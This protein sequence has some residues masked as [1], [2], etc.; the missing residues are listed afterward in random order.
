METALKTNY[1][2]GQDKQVN[3]KIILSGLITGQIAGLI[4]AVAIILVFVIF[5]GKSFYFPVQVIGSPLFGEAGLQNFHLLAFLVG[6]CLHQFGPSL[7]W[8]FIFGLIATRYPIRSTRIGLAMGLG[9]GIVS[10]VGPYLLIPI[11]MQTMQGVDI[12]A[13]EV[14]IVWSW[15]AHIVFGVSFALFPMVHEKINTL[16]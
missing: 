14:P 1:T 9:L 13:R 5:L 11:V 6:L 8:G 10:M 12:W 7:L 4:M 2:A 15:I 3:R 16:R